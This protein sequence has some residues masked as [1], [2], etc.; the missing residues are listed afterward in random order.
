MRIDFYA[1]YRNPDKNDVS[2]MSCF[3]LAILLID[4]FTMIHICC[5]SGNG[6]NP[7]FSLKYMYRLIKFLHPSLFTVSE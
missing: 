3:Q 4:G 1:S 2:G 7:K 5:K 6:H